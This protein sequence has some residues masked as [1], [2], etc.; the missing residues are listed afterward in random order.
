MR[1]KREQQLP[2]MLPKVLC[3]LTVALLAA[4]C[5]ASPAT[6]PTSPNTGKPPSTR[7]D[8]KPW[9]HNSGRPQPPSPPRARRW[10]FVEPQGG[11]EDDAPR[12]LDALHECSGG[13]G[14]TV[15]LDANYTIATALDLTF[16]EGVDIALSGR[17]TFRPDVDYWAANS[18]KYAFQ[19]SSS[20][21]RVGGTDV[22]IFGGGTL[23]GAG[24]AW[25]DAFA[26]NATLARPILFVLDGLK[27]GS[28]VGINMV[29]PPNVRIW[30]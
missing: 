1:R 2:N 15:V 21:L 3:S 12:I 10:C 28:V 4:T 26:L 7:P 6:G 23:D 25:W 11:G 16:L 13:G 20:F 27:G 24:Q 29:N 19:S 9:P 30:S 18:F 14:G 22:N 5:S 8:T 17:V